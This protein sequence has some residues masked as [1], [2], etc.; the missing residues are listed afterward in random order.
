MTLMYG[1][2]YR[3]FTGGILMLMMAVPFL[4]DAATNPMSFRGNIDQQESRDEI[5]FQRLKAASGRTLEGAD[6]SFQV[7]KSSDDVILSV[8]IDTFKSSNR[9]HRELTKLL[10]SGKII[11]RKS[12]PNGEGKQI[13]QVVARFPARSSV[14]EPAFRVLWTDK[15]R[16]YSITASSLRHVMEFEKRFL[17]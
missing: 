10:R 1:K 6:F 5:K 11:E 3:L 16:L 17:P 15:S 4:C 14:E 2:A 12:K 9:A 8:R 13:E 7:Y